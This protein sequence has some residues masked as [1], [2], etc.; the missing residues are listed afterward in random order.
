MGLV[1]TILKL[2]FL[3]GLDF[4]SQKTPFDLF[5]NLKQEQLS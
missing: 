4:G 1:V 3:C 5:N 2:R